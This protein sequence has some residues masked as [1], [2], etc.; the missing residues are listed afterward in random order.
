MVKKEAGFVRFG[1]SIPGELATRFDSLVVKAGCANRSKAVR[2][3]IRDRLVAA[4]WAAGKSEM[5]GTFSMV[6]DHHVREPGDA[7]T[8]LRHQITLQLHGL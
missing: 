3:L 1:I 4:A 2:D 7:L 6:C 5:I 8:E